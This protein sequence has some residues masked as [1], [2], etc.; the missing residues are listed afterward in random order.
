MT[1]AIDPIA[2]IRAFLLADTSVDTITAGRVF[3]GE[4][5]RTE[6]VDMPRTCIVL[7]PAGGGAFGRAFESYGDVRVDVICYGATKQEAWSVLI[8]AR[9]AFKQM[10]RSVQNTVLLHW[11]RE[12]A[13]GTLGEDPET[14]W[15]T[16][17]CSFQVLAAETAAT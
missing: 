1:T 6:N 12:S 9:W 3:G 13:G 16:A 5:P 10:R 17:V 15:P 2:G 14:Q 7:A 11:A 4:L 8:A